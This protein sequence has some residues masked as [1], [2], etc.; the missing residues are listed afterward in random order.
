MKMYD[1]ELPVSPLQAALDQLS[2]GWQARRAE[3]Q[4]TLGGLIQQLEALDPK[5]MIAGLGTPMSYRGYYDDLAFNPEEQPVTVALALKGARLCMGRIFE[6][7]KGGE[8][9]MGE[10]TPVWSATHGMCGRRIM[11]LNGDGEVVQLITA[12]DKETLK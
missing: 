6:G 2:A 10:R 11:G 9:L 5:R 12:P 7:Y 4:L 3:T 1:P 8:F